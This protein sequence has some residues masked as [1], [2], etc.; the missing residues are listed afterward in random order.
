VSTGIR[1]IDA[2][3]ARSAKE[4]ED[5]AKNGTGLKQGQGLSRFLQ[6]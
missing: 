3:A 4:I 2:F 5:A 1:Y 6:K